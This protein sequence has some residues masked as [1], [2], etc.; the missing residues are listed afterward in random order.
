MAK[1]IQ[2]QAQRDA[3]KRVTVDLRQLKMLNDFID[4][5]SCDIG[6]MV[7]LTANMDGLSIKLTFDIKTAKELFL[8]QKTKMQKDITMN[9][10]KFNITLDDSEKAILEQ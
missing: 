10:T 3:L 4:K 9:V 8:K 7:V 5:I 1:I 6:N 2:T